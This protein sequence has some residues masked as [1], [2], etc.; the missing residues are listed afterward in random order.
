MPR[1][2]PSICRRGSRARGHA[3]ARVGDD[4][5]IPR[6]APHDRTAGA[7][8]AGRIDA[9]VA[10]APAH[11][12]LA[13]RGA[14]VEAG[15]R[16]LDL[17]LAT[18]REVWAD[19]AAR[20]YAQ[21]IAAQWDPQIAIPW[22]APIDHPAEVETAIV[23][24]MTFLVENETAALLVPVRFLGRLHPHFREVMQLLRD[25]S[26][27]QAR[28]IEVFTRRAQ[29][30]RDVLGL[31]TVGGQA[32]LASLFDEPEFAV[33]SFLLAVLGEGSFLALLWFL[34][35][36]APDAC[37]REVARLAAQDEARHVAFGLA[38]LARH[39]GEEPALRDRL[40]AAIERRHAALAHTAGL[41]AEVFDA[42]VLLAAGDWAPAALRRGHA[43]VVALV[44]EMDLGRRQRLV[45]LGFAPDRAAQLSALHTRN[46][47]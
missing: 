12:G 33:A 27:R 13:A 29:L 28:H 7:E 44:G 18:K 17:P 46:F 19:E 45:R 38:H 24:I 9:P 4:F 5:A 37:T 15:A 39:V 8:R 10:E 16:E 2:S 20:L 47:M 3:C 40:A 30:R 25:P 11:W 42:L 22:G 32:S 26:R 14:L 6:D 43:A 23:Q 36:H 31:S 21:A 1:R 35:D 34:R 41:N